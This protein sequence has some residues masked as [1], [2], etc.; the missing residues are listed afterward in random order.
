MF[1]FMDVRFY[2][3]ESGG[4]PVK[5]YL[6]PLAEKQRKMVGA[7]IRRIQDKSEIPSSAKAVK[8]RTPLC[9]LSVG[10]HRVFYVMKGPMMVLLHAYQK[11]SQ[12]APEREM[13]VAEERMHKVLAE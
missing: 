6:R 10:F 7:V 8:G 9:E 11:N 4:E 5:E 1:M 3:T 12:A 13:R 2:Q